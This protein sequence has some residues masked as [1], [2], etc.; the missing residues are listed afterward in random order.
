MVIILVDT[1]STHNFIDQNV[2]KKVGVHTQTINDTS[3]L[4]GE[5]GQDVD[6]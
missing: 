6:D 4:V 5:W 1:G 3:V 2:V